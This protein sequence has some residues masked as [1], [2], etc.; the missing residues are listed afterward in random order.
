MCIRDRFVRAEAEVVTDSATVD[1]IGQ[2]IVAG[3]QGGT[4]HRAHRR[5]LDNET[6]T[7][8]VT[9]ALFE[10]NRA[11]V[12]YEAKADNNHQSGGDRNQHAASSCVFVVVG[13]SAGDGDSGGHR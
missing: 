5:D 4:T 10:Y 6:I 12:P 9:V 7:A 11:Q 3:K 8:A 2:A 13:I 1:E